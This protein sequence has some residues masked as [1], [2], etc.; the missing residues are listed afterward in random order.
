MRSVACRSAL[1]LAALIPASTLTACKGGSS[2]GV[3]EAAGLGSAEVIV[4][5]SSALLTQQVGLVRITVR[6]AG[7]PDVLQD[8]TRVGDTFQG[9]VNRL[10]AG[11]DRIFIAEAR[12][13]ATGPVLFRGEVDKVTIE[14]GK[15]AAVAIVLQEAIAKTPFQNSAP[16]ILALSASN[17][18]VGPRES[19]QVRVQAMDPDGDSLRIQW[20]SPAGVFADASKDETTWTAPDGAVSVPLAVR[21]SDPKGASVTMSVTVQ[22]SNI[23]SAAVSATFNLWPEVRSISAAPSA[24]LVPG[25]AVQL[26]ADVLDRDGDALTYIWTHDCSRGRFNDARLASPTFTVDEVDPRGACALTVDVEDARKGKGRGTLSLQTAPVPTGG[27]P[28]VIEAQ[29]QSILEAVPG[30]TVELRFRARDPESQP[31]TVTWAATLGTLGA[32]QSLGNGEY[33]MLWTAPTNFGATPPAPPPSARVQASVRDNGGQVTL[34]TFFVAPD[35]RDCFPGDASAV[36]PRPADAECINTQSRRVCSPLG[37]WQ[38]A[39]YCGDNGVCGGGLCV[40]PPTANLALWLRGDRG[41]ETQPG[42]AVSRWRDQS[43]LGNDAVPL[44]GNATTVQAAAIAGYPALTFQGSSM[45]VAHHPSIDPGASQSFTVAA[46]VRVNVNQP[47]PNPDLTMLGILNKSSHGTIQGWQLFSRN[48]AGNFAA[49][50]GALSGVLSA[51]SLDSRYRL[52]TSTYHL[53]TAVFERSPAQ[54]SLSV[55]GSMQGRFAVPHLTGNL[56]TSEP[57]RIGVERTQ[58]YFMHGAIAEVLYYGRALPD[59]DR[60]VA[61]TYLAKK[62]GLSLAP[63]TCGGG[64]SAC[65]ANNVPYCAALQTDASNCG[66][67]GRSCLGGACV[68]GVCQPVALASGMNQPAGIAIDANNVYFTTFGGGSVHRVAKNGGPVALLASGV[69][70]SHGIVT[71]G[72]AVYWANLTS[73]G[74]IRRVPVGGGSVSSLTGPLNGPAWPAL[75]NGQV[76]WANNGAG[77][78]MRVPTGGGPAETLVSGQSFPGWVAPSA[79]GLFWSNNSASGSVY[80]AGVSGQSPTPIATALASPHRVVVHNGTVYWTEAGSGRIMRSGTD[81]SFVS[82]VQAEPAGP[83]GLVVDLSHLYWTNNQTGTISRRVRWLPGST[84]I[85]SGQGT[86]KDLA[87]D[88][89]AIYWTNFGDGRVMRL[90][91]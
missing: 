89:S 83:E 86:P 59:A 69:P 43:G 47:V 14:A 74:A 56:S 58:R 13:S 51:E 24:R 76:Y 6:A 45:Q 63:S 23:G 4:S 88:A 90:A 34:V 27:Q 18:N 80:R 37:R 53:V 60:A 35:T 42:G 72:T 15:T 9:V 81:G 38:A 82:L 64:Q 16:R 68:A 52:E 44:V 10:P 70:Q 57:L 25:Q 48:P 65:L 19:I 73:T 1:L 41:V 11:K 39:E 55:N 22:V 75:F 84:V 71:D 66:V 54:V 50:V 31:L 29:Y 2:Y 32:P 49:E 5:S 79:A 61:E 87:E 36:P 78:I 85:A 33:R 26:T 17:T 28:P 62:Y 7:V 21:V 30:E 40:A 77:T 67:C 20:T 91:K 12:Q 46:V 3:D 8:L